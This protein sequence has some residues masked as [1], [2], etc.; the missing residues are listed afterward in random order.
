M[1]MSSINLLVKDPQAALATYIQLFGTNNIHEALQV[2]GLNNGYDLVDGYYLKTQPM[3]V[4]IWA[5]RGSQ[6]K[7]GRTLQSGGEGIHHLTFQLGQDEFESTYLRLKKEGLPVSERITYIGKLSEAVFWLDGS[8]EQGVP[9]QFATKCYRG[10]QIWDQ[11]DY[12]DTPR[13]VQPVP[14]GAEVLRPPMVLTTAIVTVEESDKARQVWSS[15]LGREPVE[16]GSIFTL[17]PGQVN[18]GRG[19][20]FIPV[21]FGFKQSKGLNLYRAINPEGPIN[22]VMRKRGVKGMYHNLAGY[23]MRDRLHEYFGQLEEA[24]FSMVDPKPA[25]NANKGNGNYFFFVHPRS[26]YGVLWEMVSMFTR[27]ESIKARYDW[28][29]VQTY[30]LPPETD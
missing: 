28:T 26:T 11:T 2:T 8:G 25:L 6:G 27:D 16:Q 13:K 23:V 21:R 1:D 12:L 9:M 29:G 7:M 17:E 20:I 15:I 24:G 5:P 19:N 22:K 30:M 18:D 14:L 3:N 10:L 4:G